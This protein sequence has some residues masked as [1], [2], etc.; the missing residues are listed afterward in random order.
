MKQR[1]SKRNYFNIRRKK[2]RIHKSLD[3]SLSGTRTLV[4]G[5]PASTDVNSIVDIDFSYICYS[6]SNLAKDTTGYSV[7]KVKVTGLSGMTFVSYANIISHSK[8]TVRDYSGS[9][10][11]FESPF[12]DAK[13]E[14]LHITLQPDNPRGLRR[15]RWTM[16]FIP[17]RNTNDVTNLVQS[18]QPLE[19]ER[20]QSLPG[21]VTSN[22]DR[23]IS[24]SFRPKPEDGYCYQ[25]NSTSEPFGIL[26]IAYSAGLR[27]KYVAIS[28]EDFSPNITVSG[29]VRV[30]Q[31]ILAIGSVKTIDTVKRFRDPPYATILFEKDQ[32]AANNAPRFTFGTSGINVVADNDL[33]IKGSIFSPK[34]KDVDYLSLDSM[35][36]E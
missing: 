11:Q 2:K 22:A 3:T 26:C 36:L 8:N 33:T 10:M 12:K 25:Y 9:R 19:F 27:E 35:A 13:L 7:T 21:A 34:L 5:I 23:K 20:V 28:T 29:R 32:S 1:N 16:A 14:H 31:P 4:A 18:Y 30:Q 15:G 17:I 6:G 24:L